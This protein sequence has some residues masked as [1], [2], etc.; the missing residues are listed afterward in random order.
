[1]TLRAHDLLLAVCRKR[2]AILDYDS[3]DRQEAIAVVD[4]LNTTAEQ[5]F[6]A[7]NTVVNKFKL[8]RSELEKMLADL[9]MSD[10]P[11]SQKPCP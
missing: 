11:I 6:D 2:L 5:A 1:L 4:D 10:V 7:V 8:S 3:E 9:G